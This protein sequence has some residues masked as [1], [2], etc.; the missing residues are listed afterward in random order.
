MIHS[1]HKLWLMSSASVIKQNDIENV[2][3]RNDNLKK[4]KIR[5]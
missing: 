5:N 2:H 1:M 3:I 4:V